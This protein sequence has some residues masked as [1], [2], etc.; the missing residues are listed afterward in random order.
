MD[1]LSLIID[2]NSKLN[3]KIDIGLRLSNNLKYNNNW[4]KFGFNEKD[5]KLA[6]NKIKSNK[7][8]NLIGLSS[9]LG[10]NISDKAIYKNFASK[11]CKIIK[12]YKI[13]E[14]FDFQYVDIGGGFPSSYPLK[15]DRNI[16]S[17]RDSIKEY[18]ESIH[19]GCGNFFNNNNI[20]LIIE[21][22]RFLVDESI[23]CIASVV[24]IKK[25]KSINRV[26]IDVGSNAIPSIKYKYHQVDQIKKRGKK[27]DLYEVHGPLCMS[28]DVFLEKHKFYNI[29]VGDKL[30]IKAC[31]AYTVSQSM[32]FIKQLPNVYAVGKKNRSYKKLQWSK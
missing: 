25:S 9:H 21:P 15:G 11:I 4:S 17:P 13:L 16:L 12:N 7:L 32:P 1:E 3:I 27:A 28:S 5:L 24:S 30:I 20:K 2:I 8:I 29:R 14:N 18:I 19:S 22:G 26:F 10:G 6:L 23:Q 31:G